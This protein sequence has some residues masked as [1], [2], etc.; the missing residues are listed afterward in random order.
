MDRQLDARWRAR[1]SPFDGDIL[2]LDD[3]IPIEAL[4]TALLSVVHVLEQNYGTEHLYALADWHEHDGYLTQR[5][6]TTWQA[7]GQTLANEQSLCDCC[8]GEKFVRRLFYSSDTKF[9]LRIYV[10]HKDEEDDH[11][12]L[13]GDFDLSGPRNI[14]E[15]V[16][17]GLPETTQNLMRFRP[18]QVHFDERYAG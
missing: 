12:G 5:S 8:A 7:L 1:Q 9:V 6:Y 11:P 3:L 2:Y 14:L 4:R 10:L 18:A 16:S 15:I 13:W 17:R